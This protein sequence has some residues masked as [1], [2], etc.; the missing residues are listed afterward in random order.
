MNGM[1]QKT[2]TK[3]KLFHFHSSPVKKRSGRQPSATIF[4]TVWRGV[5]RAVGWFEPPRGGDD[6]DDDDGN[7]ERGVFSNAERNPE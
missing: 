6:D 4:A 5:L 3:S 1:Q 7:S 2:M